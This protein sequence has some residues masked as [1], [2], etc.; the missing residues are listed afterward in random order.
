MYIF[1]QATPVAPVAP[2]SPQTTVPQTP[3]TPVNK[4]PPK[5]PRSIL[6]MFNSDTKRRKV[7]FQEAKKGFEFDSSSDESDVLEVDVIH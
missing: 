4:V 3:K 7:A 2:L 1:H 5:T 6:R